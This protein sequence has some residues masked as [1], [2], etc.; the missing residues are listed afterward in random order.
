MPAQHSIF[1]NSLFSSLLILSSVCCILLLISPITLFISFCVFSSCRIFAW[2]CLNASSS[3]LWKNINIYSCSINSYF[4][5]LHPSIWKFQ[6]LYGWFLA[7]D[8]ALRLG[9]GSL[10][11][12]EAYWSMLSSAHE[13]IRFSSLASSESVL[14][15]VLSSL[16]FWCCTCQL[17]LMLCVRLL[18]QDYGNSSGHRSRSRPLSEGTGVG[19]GALSV[20]SLLGWVP[21]PKIVLLFL[22]IYPGLERWKR[23]VLDESHPNFIWLAFAVLRC[24]WR[25][26]GARGVT[27]HWRCSYFLI[28]M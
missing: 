25:P 8:F 15:E 3:L 10:K 16:W 2:F 22:A 28:L 12:P 17:L 14:L 6:F 20:C 5:N 21:S 18:T 1:L 9:Y 4:K 27:C 24:A 26:W 23:Q 19:T 13:R 11:F 7:R